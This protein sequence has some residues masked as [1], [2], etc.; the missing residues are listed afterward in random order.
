MKLAIVSAVKAYVSQVRAN[1]FELAKK[2]VE[3]N[4]YV[5]SKPVVKKD[6]K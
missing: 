4:G 1:A 6:N 3:R 2:T 5:V